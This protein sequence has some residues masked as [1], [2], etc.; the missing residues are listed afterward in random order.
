M[1][2]VIFAELRLIV[3]A[4]LCEKLAEFPDALR[5]VELFAHPV[6]RHPDSVDEE[7]LLSVDRKPA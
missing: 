4:A 6:V 7:V 3:A 5:A 1:A 2:A